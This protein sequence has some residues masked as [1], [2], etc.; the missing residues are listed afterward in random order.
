[1]SLVALNANAA[2]CGAHGVA[3][4]VLGSGGPEL[5]DKRACSSY[6]IWRD[7][8]PRVLVDSG[9]GS[10]RASVKAARRSQIWM[11]SY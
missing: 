2:G 10:A 3:V 7:G 8:V 5:Q 4:Q 6:L 11:S 1:M 9:G